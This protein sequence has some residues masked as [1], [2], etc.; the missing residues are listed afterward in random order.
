MKSPEM[1]TTNFRRNA[2][3]LVELLVV[4]AII[5]I[6]IGMWLPAVQQ[7]REAARRTN[8]LNNSVQLGL[9]THNYEFAHEHL[10]PGTINATGPIVNQAKGQ[11]V[12]FLVQLLSYLEQ[13]G[14]ADNFDQSL[15]S[16]APENL[17]AREMSIPTFLCPSYAWHA[18]FGDLDVGLNNYA[19]CHH[20]SEV[21]I[22]EDN[23]G[24]LFLN[25]KIAYGEIKD[26]ASNT[27]LIGEMLP[28][29]GHLGWASGTRS[30]LRNTS[31]LV[32]ISNG[33]RNRR[34]AAAADDGD[35]DAVGGFGSQ[36]SGG[37]NVCL[38][39]GSARF[40]SEAIDSN[41]LSWIGSRA[42]LEMMGD[43]Q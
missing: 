21:P 32:S 4:I 43:W 3:T 8:C 41:V 17:A 27:I 39:D 20:G 9:A 37:V 2:F 1:T 18:S 31:E 6:L 24:V 22:D 42:D 29:L 25:S 16:Y 5:G 33:R 38:A 28:K 12:G 13:Q 14:I 19:G 11:H 15:G 35:D 10:P 26:G 36:H 30:T 34:N 40:I 7:V 23:N